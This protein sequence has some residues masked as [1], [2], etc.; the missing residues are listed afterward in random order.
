MTRVL[1]SI[2]ILSLVAGCG[3]KRALIRPQEIPAFEEK[4]RKKREQLGIEDPAA[5]ATTEKTEDAH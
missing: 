3:V 1:L 4:Q 5:N 2:M